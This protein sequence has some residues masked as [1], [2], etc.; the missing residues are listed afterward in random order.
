[1]PQTQIYLDNET[2]IAFLQKPKLERERIRKEAANTIKDEVN[3][4]GN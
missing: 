2:Y 4:N 3:E 1:M